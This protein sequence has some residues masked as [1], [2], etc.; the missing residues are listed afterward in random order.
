MGGRVCQ[1]IC[2]NMC[3]RVCV[4]ARVHVS[5]DNAYIHTYTLAGGRQKSDIQFRHDPNIR[6]YVFSMYVRARALVCVSVVCVCVCV[7]VFVCVYCSLCDA[8]TRGWLYNTCM[9]VYVGIYARMVSVT[10]T[11]LNGITRVGMCMRFKTQNLL[12]PVSQ[13]YAYT[14]IMRMFQL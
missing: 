3:L 14:H 5:Q 11:N 8:T 6:K 7:C 9:Y 13:I 12:S 1:C 10:H 4:C 2:Q